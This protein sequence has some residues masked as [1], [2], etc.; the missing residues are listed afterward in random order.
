MS[1]RGRDAV[2][3][4]C[5]SFTYIGQDRL[6][7]KFEDMEKLS[8]K[9]RIIRTASEL[10][11]QNGYNLTGINEIIAKAEIAK[12]TLY[13]HFSSK[14][15]L[16]IAYLEARDE[17]LLKDM[18]A[19][20]QTKPQGDERLLGVLAFLIPFFESGNFHGCWCIRTVAEIPRNNERIHRKIRENKDAFKRFIEGLVADN[21]P[22]MTQ[23]AQLQLARRIYLLYE[24]AV[25]ESHLQ[26][27]SWPIVENIHLLQTLLKKE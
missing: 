15:D 27:H 4:D 8:A 19:F 23:E 11:Y 12:A 2:I 18:G 10:F 6:V 3:T 24:G 21:R 16:C 5:Y 25:M 22:E 14:E 9:E 13:S 26:N 1:I 20:C 17:Q 7:C